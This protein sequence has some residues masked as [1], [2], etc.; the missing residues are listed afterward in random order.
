MI[1]FNIIEVLV[2]EVYLYYIREREYY[3]KIIDFNY[4]RVL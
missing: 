4:I 1:L 3:R 2:S